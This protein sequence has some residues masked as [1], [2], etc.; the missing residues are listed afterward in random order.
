MTTIEI[1]QKAPDFTLKDSFGNDVSLSDFNGKKVVLYFYPRDLTPGCTNQA[2]NLRD[3]IQE[4]QKKGIVVLGLSFDDEKKHQKFIEKHSLPSAKEGFN[5]LCDIDKTVANLYGI[6][7]EKNMYGKKVMG[8]VRTTFLINE[9]GIIVH[10]FKKPKV[11]EHSEE[12]FAWL[13]TH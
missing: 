7:R 11:K 5:L 2:C 4:L 1:N 3:H 9:K 6:Y 8:I 12:I 10:I 13:D